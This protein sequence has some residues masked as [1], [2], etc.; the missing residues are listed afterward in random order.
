MFT[1][2]RGV[3]NVTNDGNALKSKKHVS[4]LIASITNIITPDLKISFKL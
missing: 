1:Q 2:N 4:I 3:I